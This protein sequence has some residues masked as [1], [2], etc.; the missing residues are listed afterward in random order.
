MK[1][2]AISTLFDL[3]AFEYAEI[4][5]GCEYPWQVLEKI[6]PYILQ[7]RKLGKIEVGIPEGAHLLNPETISIGKGTV[8]EPGAYIKGPCLIGENCTIRQGAYIR[9][10]VIAGNHCVIGHDSEVKNSIFLN[11][12][13]AAH[14]A[15]VG[16][17]VLG[18]R[19]NL[20]AGS[21]LANL[22]IDH[23]EVTIWFFGEKYTSGR[24]KCGAM[25]GDDT[26]IGC[27]SV[28]NPGVVCC[29]NVKCHPCINFG[30]FIPENAII[31]SAHQPVIEQTS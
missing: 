9:G 17:S 3:S 10:D 28:A 18:N 12:A 31:R 1:A 14:F 7:S 20:G 27:N 11:K 30:G 4:F 21:K 5:D 19:T 16:D 8:I 26:H 22:R 23:R 6:H 13:N 25:L 2:F 29:K 15:Y 24:K